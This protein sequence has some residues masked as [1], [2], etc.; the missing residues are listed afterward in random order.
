M[1]TVPVT[2]LQN[3]LPEDMPMPSVD[4]NT[5]LVTT[6]IEDSTHIPT[7]ETPPALGCPSMT[8]PLAPSVLAPTPTPIIVV[9]WSVLINKVQASNIPAITIILHPDMPVAHSDDAMV[10]PISKI[11][12]AESAPFSLEPKL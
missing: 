8:A 10:T 3:L 2:Q 9:D 5:W 1:Y 6:A 7:Q 12:M 4:L 11:F